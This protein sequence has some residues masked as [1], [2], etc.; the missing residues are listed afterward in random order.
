MITPG[1]QL[2]PNCI[3]FEHL[4]NN[5][6]F[7]SFG[8]LSELDVTK[9]LFL[10]FKNKAL[11]NASENQICFAFQRQTEIFSLFMLENLF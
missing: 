5:L 2:L 3:L 10:K 9:V 8:D 1:S 4:V 6:C 7:I 11:K